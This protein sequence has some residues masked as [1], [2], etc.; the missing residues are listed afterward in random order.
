MYRL[1][2]N[3]ATSVFVPA[4]FPRFGPDSDVFAPLRVR[5]GS[6]FGK[7]TFTPGD[8]NEMLPPELEP[9]RNRCSPGTS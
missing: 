6:E 3:Y 8:R 7:S 4:S 5:E 2:L 9:R 1:L